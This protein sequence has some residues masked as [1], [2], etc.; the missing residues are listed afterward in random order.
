MSA[1]YAAAWRALEAAAVAHHAGDL[2][3]TAKAL[4]DAADAYARAR[5]ARNS[6]SN[7]VKASTG[8]GALS[9]VVV[10]FGRSKGTPIEQADTKDL[11][12]VASALAQSIDN[13]EKAR[14]RDEN[15]RTL[16]AIQRELGTR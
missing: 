11:R 15:E 5:W 8:P 2:G 16:A 10:P 7:G 1:D 3:P 12:W 9:G 6:G 14:W 13:P 4:A